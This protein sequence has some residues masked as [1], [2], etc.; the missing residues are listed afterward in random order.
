MR[1]LIAVAACIV[2]AGCSDGQRNNAPPGMMEP[3]PA[4]PAPV[5]FTGLVK[6]QFAATADDTDPVEINEIDID[7]DSQSDPAAFDDLLQ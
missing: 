1:L 4:P 6:D 2:V 7:F 3:E 5:S